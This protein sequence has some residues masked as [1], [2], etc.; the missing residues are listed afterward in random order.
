MKVIQILVQL[1]NNT[2]KIIVEYQFDSTDQ[3]Q[4]G[5]DVSIINGR[6]VSADMLHTGNKSININSTI[7]ILFH[8]YTESMKSMLCFFLIWE[9]QAVHAWSKKIYYWSTNMWIYA[10]GGPPPTH[11]SSWLGW[12]L[13]T[14]FSYWWAVYPDMAFSLR[15]PVCLNPAPGLKK[16]TVNSQGVQS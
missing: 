10:L 11:P 13:Y 2:D 6:I 8:N 5:S 16:P 15:K 9:Q 4:G 14:C 7:G 1:I 12:S 3:S